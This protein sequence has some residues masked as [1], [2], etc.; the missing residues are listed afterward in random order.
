MFNQEGKRSAPPIWPYNQPITSHML[1]MIGKCTGYV[2]E[3]L[4]NMLARYEWFDCYCSVIFFT[5][6]TSSNST[7]ACS[8]S[9]TSIFLWLPYCH[10]QH[11]LPQEGGLCTIREVTS[12][13][14]SYPPESSPCHHTTAPP[15]GDPGH[16]P[17]CGAPWPHG[18]AVS[19]EEFAWASLLLPGLLGVSHRQLSLLCHHRLEMED[20]HLCFSIAA[21]TRHLI[22]HSFL[23]AWCAEVW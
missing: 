2:Q 18:A 9:I 19:G 6:P 1:E 22:S 16:P 3:Y 8:N 5:Q 10:S 13:P 4:L 23:L 21:C 15:G 12:P 14:L 7:T 20:G 17:P 11:T